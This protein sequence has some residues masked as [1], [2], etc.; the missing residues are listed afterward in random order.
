[1]HAKKHIMFKG[2]GSG[3]PVGQGI[4]CL[5]F[6]SLPINMNIFLYLNYFLKFVNNFVI[7]N[8]VWKFYKHEHFSKIINN[9]QNIDVLH[10]LQAT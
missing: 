1:M 2:G 8:C 3:R 5:Q 6:L 10:K 7:P 9:F 4:S